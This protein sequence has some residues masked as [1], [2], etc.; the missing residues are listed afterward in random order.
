MRGPARKPK[1]FKSCPDAAISIG[2]PGCVDV[3]SANHHRP[4]GHPPTAGNQNVGGTHQ[5]QVSDQAEHILV[6]HGEGFTVGDRQGKSG[7]LKQ[8]AHIAH[9]GKGKNAWADSADNFT[10]RLRQAL[11]QFSQCGTTGKAAKEK[12]VW[13]EAPP[14]LDENARQIIGVL[15][16]Q[17]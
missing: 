6:A 17:A 2:K 14:E 1:D 4:A 5:T 9:I 10:L 15:E 16:Y 3:R 13:F 12:P 7:P 11:P 8:T